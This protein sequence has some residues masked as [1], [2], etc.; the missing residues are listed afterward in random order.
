MIY[1]LL[2]INSLLMILLPLLLGI[3]LARRYKVGWLLF[4]IGALGFVVSQVG[5]LTF[6]Q[7][8]LNPIIASLME[9][10]DTIGRNLLIA[11]LLGL[12][13]GV[14]EEVTRYLFYFFRKSMRRWDQG[15]MFGAGWGGIESII[16]GLLA[17]TTIVNLYIYQSG[18]I[19]SL[20]PADALTENA[21]AIA[22]G[23]QQFEELLNSPPWYFLL[24]TV[25]RI[26]ALTLHLSLSILVLQAFLRK[27]IIWLFVAIGWHALV[28]GFAVFGSL[29]GWDVLLIEAGVAVSAIISF[30]IIRY[31]KP[32]DI[33]AEED[34]SAAN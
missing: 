33:A 16:L 6:N 23:A 9:Q 2:A 21:A 7:F 17:A 4:L 5:H 8:I 10:A 29:Q 18:A 27:S 25:E 30:L 19:E 24:G 1:V 32:Q 12:S 34:I 11:L 26:F 15:L 14:F 22:A 3:W 28:N 20:L 31:F 13:A